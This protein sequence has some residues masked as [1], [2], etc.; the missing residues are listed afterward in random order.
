MPL[1]SWPTIAVTFFGSPTS[2]TNQRSPIEASFDPTVGTVT[3]SAPVCSIDTLVADAGVAPK[4]RAPPSVPIEMPGHGDPSRLAHTPARVSLD[5]ANVRSPH[6][7]LASGSFAVAGGVDGP[8]PTIGEGARSEIGEAVGLRRHGRLDR[9]SRLVLRQHFRDRLLPV[10]VGHRVHARCERDHVVPRDAERVHRH[11]QPARLVDPHEG[12]VRLRLRPPRVPAGR[13]PAGSPPT[14]GRDDRAG[15]G[16]TTSASAGALR[17]RHRDRRVLRLTQI[18]GT[19]I[20]ELPRR[21]AVAH[22]RVGITAVHE[23][24]PAEERRRVPSFGRR[25]QALGEPEELFLGHAGGHDGHVV[26][27]PSPHISIGRGRRSS[28]RREHGAG[29]PW[30]CDVP[31]RSDHHSRPGLN[32]PTTAGSVWM[33]TRMAVGRPPTGTPGER[34]SCLDQGAWPRPPPAHVVARVLEHPTL[35]DGG[36]ELRQRR[37]RARRTDLQLIRSG[38]HRL[39]RLESRGRWPT[40]SRRRRCRARRRHR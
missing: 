14:P 35:G 1:S 2:T 10:G 17:R 22:R 38:R 19:V 23:R 31:S 29:W 3:D 40:R 11:H 13:S 12:A 5:P 24:D 36:Q 28:G 39:A 37:W 20:A 4:R 15:L 9:S 25:L 8:R 27:S 30:T 21:T 33:S 18:L 34:R 32:P 7:R 16:N 6:T 26:C